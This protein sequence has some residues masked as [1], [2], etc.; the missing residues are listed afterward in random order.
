MGLKGPRG[1]VC[2]RPGSVPVLRAPGR[3]VAQTEKA[4]R[5]PG[6]PSLSDCL[7][8]E[9]IDVA[10]GGRLG[11]GHELVGNGPDDIREG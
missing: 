9:R 11:L 7:G 10:N 5:E 6:L 1:G 8:C 2:S 4:R 3:I